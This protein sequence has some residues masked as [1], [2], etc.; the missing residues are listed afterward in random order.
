VP[1]INEAQHSPFGRS[2]PALPEDFLGRTLD[3]WSVLQ[4]LSQRRAVVVCGAENEEFGI[5]KSAVMDAVHRSFALQMG[6]VCVAVQIRS[7]SHPPTVKT[8]WIEKT[9]VAVKAAAKECRELWQSQGQGLRGPAP[10]RRP[11][12]NGKASSASVSHGFHPLSADDLKWLEEDS[13]R[14]AQEELFDEL[15]SLVELC[16]ARCK[17]WPAQSGR[18]LLLLDEVDHIVQQ[19]HFQ[20]AV[21]NVLQRWPSLS[22]VLSTHQS[23]VGTAG[24]HFKVVH[25]KL[26]GLQ[27]RDA[28]RLFLRRSPRPLHWG[29][30]IEAPAASRCS[31]QLGSPSELVVLT[32]ANEGRVLDL[33]ASQQCLA[34][35][36]GNPRRLIALAS[37]LEDSLQKVSSEEI[38][39]ASSSTQ[40]PRLL[41]DEASNE[42]STSSDSENEPLMEH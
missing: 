9:K 36:Q 14:V 33:L 6:G 7:L 34:A 37:R 40:T 38:S 16:E 29:E 25:H 8:D 31:A 23:M 41:A 11:I 28:A 26:Q 19:Q 30:L 21:A 5:G 2:V 12:R 4:H 22:V 42:V 1:S 13:L 35:Q 15:Q 17:D 18:I 24:G 10:R 27:K 32:K 39:S 3:V 20:D